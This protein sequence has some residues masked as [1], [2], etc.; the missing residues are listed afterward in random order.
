ME[1][2]LISHALKLYELPYDDNIELRYH[3]SRNFIEVGDRNIQDSYMLRLY[4]G[5]GDMSY[6]AIFNTSSKLDNNIR[7]FINHWLR[8]YNVN[9]KIYRV[10]V[11]ECSHDT[12][13]IAILRN[14]NC[15]YYVLKSPYILADDWIMYNW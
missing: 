7:N 5:G 6:E 8:C 12:F 2:G 15:L 4:R 3:K 14:D 10:A 1:R 13:D 9:E 11:R